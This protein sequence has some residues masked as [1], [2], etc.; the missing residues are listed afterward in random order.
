MK[1][2]YLMSGPHKKYGFNERIN[3]SLKK[4]LEGKEYIEIK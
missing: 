2:I 1:T 4:E 3:E